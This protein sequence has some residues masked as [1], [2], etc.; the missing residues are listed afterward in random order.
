MDPPQDR[1]TSN[2]ILNVRRLIDSG[3]SQPEVAKL[4]GI[5]QSAV[6][7]IINGKISRVTYAAAADLA[8]VIGI[9]LES[10][11]GSL[12]PPPLSLA[13]ASA[14]TFARTCGIDEATL[15]AF[16]DMETGEGASPEEM[17][18]EIKALD[19]R[20]KRRAGS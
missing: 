12:R 5:S 20:R 15:T 7:N 6:S 4:L 9:P 3:K 13:L 14:M 19:Q 8:K 18:I 11:M 1:F 10:M 17:W 2:Y 16:T